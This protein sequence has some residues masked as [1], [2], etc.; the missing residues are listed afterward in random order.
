MN[1]NYAIMV[2]QHLDKLFTTTFIAP[3]GEVT[4]LSLIVVVTKK[5][6]KFWI[7][8]DFCNLNIATKKDPYPLLF[9]EEVLNMVAGHEIY[10]VLDGFSSYH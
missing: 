2:K 9:I 5:N 7:C 1:P 6:G 3:M 4:W 10:S 8:V